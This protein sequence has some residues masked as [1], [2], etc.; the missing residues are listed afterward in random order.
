MRQLAPYALAFP[1]AVVFAASVAS[2]QTAPANRQTDKS[3]V[4]PAPTA[5]S[6]SAEPTTP[7]WLAELVE[8]RQARGSVL[9]GTSLESPAG[10]LSSEVG[11]ATFTAALRNL[12]TQQEQRSPVSPASGEPPLAG[13]AARAQNDLSGLLRATAYRLEG[14]AFHREAERD[15]AGAER[16]RR[17]ARRL[18]NE[19]RNLAR[20]VR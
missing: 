3:G 17:L 5:V 12:D 6:E 20:S 19:A 2:A 15:E 18:R 8:I 7:A 9:E 11:E 1:I 16:L 14:E 13:D 10:A 4:G